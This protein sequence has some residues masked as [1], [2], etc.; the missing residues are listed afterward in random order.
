MKLEDYK[1]IF[2]AVGLVGVLLIASP[3][4]GGAIPLQ[5][6]SSFLSFTF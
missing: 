1:L 6:G 2:A 5:A 3:A 4:I